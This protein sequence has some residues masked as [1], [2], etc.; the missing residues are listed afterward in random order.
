MAELATDEQSTKIEQELADLLH[1]SIRDLRAQWR[2]LYGREPPP[3]FK[4]D[5]LRRSIA[6]KIQEQEYGGIDPLIQRE[7]NRLVNALTVD[8]AKKLKAR[9][10]IQ[11]GSVLVRQWRGR[12]YRVTVEAD[13][14]SYEDNLYRNLSEIARKITGTRWNGPRFFGLRKFSEQQKTAPAA[15]SKQSFRRR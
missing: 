14:F 11:P 10:R 2:N 5:L 15:S 1:R 9:R 6:Y 3:S 7:L 4:Q 12:A 8:P 13:G